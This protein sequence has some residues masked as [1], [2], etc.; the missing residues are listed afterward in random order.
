[1][2]EYLEDEINI[3]ATVYRHYFCK[4]SSQMK[5][6][7]ILKPV[8]ETE[9]GYIWRELEVKQSEQKG[10]GMG[11]FAR[12]NLAVGSIIPIVGHIIGQAAGK[13]HAYNATNWIK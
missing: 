4:K 5:N 10:A 9:R 2:M 3:F 1:M 7:V 6:Y 12:T 8:K 13:T 11:V